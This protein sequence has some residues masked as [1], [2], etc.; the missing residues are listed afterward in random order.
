M[1]DAPHPNRTLS[2]PWIRN[3]RLPVYP[4]FVLPPQEVYKSDIHVIRPFCIAVD[5]NF[6]ILMDESIP[7]YYVGLDDFAT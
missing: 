2:N 4:R 6:N 5:D 1:L 7:D 3:P